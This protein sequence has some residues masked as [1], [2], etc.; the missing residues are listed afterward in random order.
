MLKGGSPDRFGY[1]WAT[2]NT[3]LPES[4]DQLKHWLGTTPL[5]SFATKR[6]LDVGCG[7]GRNSYWVAKAG[8]R[9]VVAVDVD[10]GSLNSARQNLGGMPNVSV[11]PL[12]AYDLAPDKLGAKFDAAICIGVLHHLADPPK[13]L[14]KMWSCLA[15]GGE[16]HLWCYGKQGNRI[17][18][19][20]IQMARFLGSRLPIQASHVLAKIFTA[21]IWPVLHYF[22]WKTP[23]YRRFKELSYK[24]I[25]S[26]VFDQMLPRIAHYW[27]AEDMHALVAPLG[28]KALVEEVLGNSWHVC[29]TKT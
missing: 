9:E 2:Y 20:P 24:N 5:E 14:E 6:V 12:S 15:S 1:E 3:I 22:P 25:E 21:M 7:M 11:K 29:V 23:Y 17:W 27:T 18:L 26:I 4:R 13:A 28:G 16:L 10:E 8:A 19:V